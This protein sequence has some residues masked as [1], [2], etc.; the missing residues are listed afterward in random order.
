MSVQAVQADRVKLIHLQYCH[1]KVPV[2]WR[3]Y[4]KEKDI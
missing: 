1:L 4:G 3:L 2:E